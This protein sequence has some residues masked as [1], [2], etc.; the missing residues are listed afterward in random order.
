MSVNSFLFYKISVLYL[1]IPIILFFLGWLRIGVGLFFSLLLV[2]AVSTFFKMV[3]NSPAID[4]S[5]YIIKEHYIAFII[6]FLFLLSTGNTGFVGCWGYD[7]PWRNAIYQDLIRQPWPVIYD[8]SSSILC[9]YMAFWL[10]P[11]EI[12]SLLHLNE[13]G[14]NIVLFLWMYMGLIL[15]FFLL[16]DILQPKREQIILITIIFLFF[17]GI[18]TLGMLLKS[19]FIEPTPLITNYPSWASWEFTNFNINGKD[20]V[21]LM[22][23]TYL[24]LADIYNQYFALTLSTLMLLKFRHKIGCYAFVG[25]LTLPYSPIGFIGLFV[26]ELSE[27]LCKVLKNKKKKNW[28]DCIKEPFSATNVFGILA[29]FPVFYFYYSMNVNASTVLNYSHSTASS[30]FYVPWHQFSGA[31]IILLLIYYYIYFIAYARL[32]YDSYKNNNLYWIILLCLVIFPFF[33]IGNSADFTFNATIC[34]YF[35]LCVFIIKHILQSL[36]KNNFRIKDLVLLF[37]LS[38]AML[39]PVIQI[40]SS[41]RGTYING[42]VSYK[43]KTLENAW[44]TSLLRDSFRDKKIDGFRNF[45]AQDY[46]EKIFYVYFLKDH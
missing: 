28:S 5:F 13:F 1:V 32:I 6:L 42:L 24:N 33:K 23:S 46:T 12:S 9:Y 20:I 8:Y 45:L 34:P 39:T 2:L 40:T 3:K 16:N 18:N 22:R 30:F 10:V 36:N 37:F 43:Y 26:V 21:Y 7:I 27:F 19:F 4:N 29:I 15:I 35:I 11:A 17:S 38:I 41:L 31:N 44:D 25:L 14:S